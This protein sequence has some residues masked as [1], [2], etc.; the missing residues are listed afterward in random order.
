VPLLAVS[1][2]LAADPP[3]PA[4][5]DDQLRRSLEAQ[6][7]D[8]DGQLLGE[9]DK[10]PAK[11]PATDELQTKLRRQLG[12]AAAKEE[13]NKPPLRLAA[14][15]MAEARELLARGKSDAIT[16]HVQRQVV[17]DLQR[18]IEQAMQSGGSGGRNNDSGNRKPTGSGDSQAKTGSNHSS[19][20]AVE[21]P[22]AASDPDLLRKLEQARAERIEQARKD[23]VKVYSLGLQ[24]H[25]R[26][27]MLELPSEYF[28]PEY[29]SDIAD[30]FRRL[31]QDAP[32]PGRPR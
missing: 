29:E 21:G 2:C 26:E 3:R 17:T 31:S 13:G 15:G 27:Q 4:S 30:Y 24:Q 10:R 6:T 20:P 22:A 23:M 7:E 18:L 12:P 5:T 19:Q 14:E 8:Y 9:P 16:Q 25:E 11:D 28:L 1:L 32:E